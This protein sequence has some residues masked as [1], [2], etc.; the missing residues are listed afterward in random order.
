MEFFSF[1]S[2]RIVSLDRVIGEEAQRV[3]VLTRGEVLEGADAQVARSDAGEDRSGHHL[4]ADDGFACQHGSQR[5]GGGDAER[6]H[7]LAHDVLAQHGA[8]RGAAVASARE[9]GRAGAFQLDVITL[10]VLSDHLA[11]KVRAAIAELRHKV[12]K[13]VP[14][15][16]HRQRLRAFGDAVARED[17]SGF[18]RACAA[19]V[20]FQERGECG[21]Q[22]DELWGSDMR[23]IHAC[24]KVAGQPG[25]AVCKGDAD[26]CRSV[27]AYWMCKRRNGTR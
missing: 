5:A 20:G 8:K 14:G 15:I 10:A 11:Q 13:L 26:G 2:F 16:R 3:L 25:I 1:S 12:G 17:F 27:H 9:R 22:L 21:V 18:F 19:Q 4:F 23:G 7:R 24:M 6:V